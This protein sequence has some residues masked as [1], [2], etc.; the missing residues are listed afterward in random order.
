MK[1]MTNNVDDMKWGQ[2]FARTKNYLKERYL[3]LKS[4]P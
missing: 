3:L 4:T 2:S 1:L